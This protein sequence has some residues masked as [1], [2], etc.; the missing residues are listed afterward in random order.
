MPVPKN[1]VEREIGN[2]GIA[3]QHGMAADQRAV[4]AGRAPTSRSGRQFL[5]P[6][7]MPGEERTKRRS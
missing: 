3:G 2:L 6:A 5:K 7:P 1:C 4:V